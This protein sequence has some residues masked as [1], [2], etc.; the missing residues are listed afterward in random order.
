MRKRKKRYICGIN[1]SPSE[2]KHAWIF[3]TAALMLVMS[4]KAFATD[5]SYDAQKVK[6]EFASLKTAE[7]Y[8]AAHDVDLTTLEATGMLAPDVT[9][10]AWTP[11]D[12][13]G[14][15]FGI[16]SF[17]WGCVLGVIGVVLVY[18]LTD[19][20][21]DESKKA[22]YGCLVAAVVGTLLQIIFGVLALG[23]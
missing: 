17:L 7:E 19:G 20:N 1:K 15:P 13:E 14:P 22:F 9:I 2:M 3:A 5:F 10:S 23:G 11:D 4:G 16:P 6:S 21:K 18:I 8:V 12:G